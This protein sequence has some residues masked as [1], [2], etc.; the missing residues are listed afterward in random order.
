MP[1]SK[2]TVT[3]GS[4]FDGTSGKGLFS[5]TFANQSTQVKVNSIMFYTSASCSFSLVVQDPDVAGNSPVILSGSGTSAYM[6]DFL[7]P[8]GSTGNWP[9]KF[10]TSGMAQNGYL[11]IDYDWVQTGR[12]G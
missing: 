1:I 11:T 5:L 12:E 10:S 8:T 7:I 4:Q 9:L 2:Q 6:T 3:A